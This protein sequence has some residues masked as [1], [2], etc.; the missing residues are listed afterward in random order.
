MVKRNMEIGPLVYWM[1]IQCSLHV[2]SSPWAPYP[3]TANEHNKDENRTLIRRNNFSEQLPK[4]NPQLY[5]NYRARSKTRSDDDYKKSLFKLQKKTADFV[6]QPF[7]SSNIASPGLIE[8]NASHEYEPSHESQNLPAFQP[9]IFQDEIHEFIQKK[10]TNNEQLQKP[11]NEVSNEAVAESRLNQG[12]TLTV[13]DKSETLITTLASDKVSEKPAQRL[14]STDP[15]TDKKINEPTKTSQ[16]PID[17]KI[18]FPQNLTSIYMEDLCEKLRGTIYETLF[19]V[20]SEQA[21]KQENI[22]KTT[23]PQNS[24]NNIDRTTNNIE[25]STDVN[26]IVEDTGKSMVDDKITTE[27][28][29]A[30]TNASTIDDPQKPA[31]DSTNK[32]TE[33]DNTS[34]PDQTTKD[35]HKPTQDPT[36]EESTQDEMT[37][38]K[39]EMTTGATTNADIPVIP[40][41]T[42][43]ETDIQVKN[44]QTSTKDSTVE[45]NTH[46]PITENKP[47]DV[48]TYAPT[49]STN[50]MQTDKQNTE[51]TVQADQQMGEKTNVPTNET[52][53]HEATEESV[54]ENTRPPMQVNIST[55]IPEQTGTDNVANESQNKPDQLIYKPE[56]S[57][58][59]I[60]VKLI[61]TQ[62]ETLFCPPHPFIQSPYDHTPIPPHEQINR[63]SNKETQY[64][65]HY[66]YHNHNSRPQYEN[67]D[68]LPGKDGSQ[69][70]HIQPQTE[71]LLVHEETTESSP[72]AQEELTQYE[73]PSDEPTTETPYEISQESPSPSD[74]AQ[75]LPDYNDDYNVQPLDEPT[76]S[77]PTQTSEDKPPEE[78]PEYGISEHTPNPPCVCPEHTHQAPQE[79]HHECKEHTTPSQ[80]HIQEPPHEINNKQQPEHQNV[81]SGEHS[82]GPWYEESPDV[83]KPPIEYYYEMP[84]DPSY[85]P[86][87]EYNQ[88]PHF[89]GKIYNHFK[90]GIQGIHK[91]KK[92]IFDNIL[93][94]NQQCRKCFPWELG[95]Q[96]N[97]NPVSNG[98]IFNRG[99]AHGNIRMHHR[100]PCCQN[101]RNGRYYLYQNY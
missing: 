98:G 93:F 51:P 37:T 76:C 9:S 28:I 52:P 16:T 101:L 53:T 83:P 14:D 64:H 1:M 39:D 84:D 41:D 40:I 3:E 78:P 68:D 24:E 32:P 22:D 21:R 95:L 35:T 73:K 33:A 11:L 25:I 56:N 20:L 65:Y 8:E 94:G 47:T 92:N 17:E 2:A 15:V 42:S 12:D 46:E 69:P 55:P 60:C 66:H 75:E 26:P 44:F 72:N 6:E 27:K 63:P 34:K 18:F 29:E 58:A 45:P 38:T 85:D 88:K 59:I 49:E 50:N 4:F 36:H 5:S 77:P 67:S 54:T 10:E 19:C 57:H 96:K 86:P 79:H 7:L 97:W 74:Y 31:N 23:T 99:Q 13:T 43:K 61:G 81:P 82:N 89:F 48:N 70:Y 80:E 30:E 90:K 62:F 87:H 100:L 91:Y 71:P